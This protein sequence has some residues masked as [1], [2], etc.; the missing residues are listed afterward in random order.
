MKEYENRGHMRIRTST[1]LSGIN[2]PMPLGSHHLNISNNNIQKCNK[3][4][5]DEQEKHDTQM[6]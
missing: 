6:M 4:Y 2:L 5:M 1:H 3:I